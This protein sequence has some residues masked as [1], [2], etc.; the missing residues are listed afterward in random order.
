MRIALDVSAVPEQLTG[1]GRYVVELARRLPASGH[2]LDLVARRGDEARW[3]ELDGAGVH[4]IVPRARGMRLLYEAWSLGLSAPARAADVWH[5]PHYTMPRRGR[6]PT[7]VT[8]HDLTFFTHPEFHE[9]TKVAYFRRAIAY[10]ATHARALIAVSHTTARLLDEHLAGHAPVVVAPHGVDVE[11]FSRLGDDERILA[12]AG[13]DS[14]TPYVLFVGTLEPRKG[15]DVLLR[16]FDLVTRELPE[17][18]L[19]VAGRP[20]WGDVEVTGARVRA[21]GYVGE[22]L[23]VSLMRHARAMAY[24]S[25]AEGFGLPVLEALASGV[26]VVTTRG[27]VMEELSGGHAFL[28]DVG[29]VESLASAIVHASSLD[30]AARVARAAAGRAHAQSFT[31]E[32]SVARHLEAYEL[33]RGQS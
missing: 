23:L 3:R 4:G 32:A 15:L 20:G 14:Q 19:W 25:R 1:A 17:L 18:E 8:I 33:A 5:G 30:A 10:S 28:S 31:W 22:D 24:P 13:L 21:L 12:A 27:T 11:H 29:D 26:P 6:T 16:A 7:V 9:P 2:Q